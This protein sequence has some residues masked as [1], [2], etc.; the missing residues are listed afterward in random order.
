V[1]DLQSNIDEDEEFEFLKSVF[2]DGWDDMDLKIYQILREEGRMTDTELAEELGTSITTARRRRTKLQDDGYLM[3]VAQLNLQE[4]EMVY[5]DVLVEIN[6]DS[7]PEELD[8]FI[9]DAIHNVR[10]YEVTQYLD[11]QQLLIRF[12]EENLKKMTDHINEFLM[13]R[14]IVEDYTLLPAARSPKAWNRVLISNQDD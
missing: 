13:D 12:Y 5:T 7:N 14:N 8:K 11:N 4:T 2:H 3:V 9:D 10:I 6:K 1:K